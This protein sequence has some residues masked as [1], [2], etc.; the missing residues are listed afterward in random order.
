[1]TAPQ[2]DIIMI[3]RDFSLEEK[4]L[5]NVAMDQF[6]QAAHSPSDWLKS[7]KAG[8]GKKIIGCFPLYIPEELIHAAGILPVVLQGSDKP[9]AR[10]GEYLHSNVCHPVQ[11]S[12]DQALRGEMHYVDGVAFA[13]ICEQAKRA[14]SLWRLY[15]TFPFRFNFLFPHVLNSPTATPYMIRELGRFKRSLEEFSGRE[16]TSSALAESIAL[17]NRTRELLAELYRRRQ[18][19]PGSFSVVEVSQILAAVQTMPKED[20]NPLLETYLA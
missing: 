19:S 20:F 15:H 7:W 11:G 17:Y 10:A 1:M 4:V 3:S 8:S 18:R 12:F 13:D 2:W 5:M 9:V 6:A 16:I 14:S